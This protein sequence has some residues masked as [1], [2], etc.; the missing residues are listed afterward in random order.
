MTDYMRFIIQ[1]YR[2]AKEILRVAGEGDYTRDT[3]HIK[4][5]SINDILEIREFV[6]ELEKHHINAKLQEITN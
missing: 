1:T 2:Y 3:E 5:L 6:S 4:L